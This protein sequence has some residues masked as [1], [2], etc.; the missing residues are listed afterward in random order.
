MRAQ[1]AFASPAF[2]P[3]GKWQASLDRLEVL[4][5]AV[6]VPSHGPTGDG[7]ALSPAIAPT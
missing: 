6:I 4:K 2:E 3:S 7:T 5:P 1:P